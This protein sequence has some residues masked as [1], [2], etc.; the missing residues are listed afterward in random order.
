MQYLTKYINSLN[1]K[2]KGNICDELFI[3]D[4]IYNFNDHHKP[5]PL[6]YAIQT[7]LD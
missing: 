7:L 4:Q 3:F 6:S 5:K 2:E 1:K